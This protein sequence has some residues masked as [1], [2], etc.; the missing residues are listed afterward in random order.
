MAPEV[1]VTLAS[2][3]TVTG[4]VYDLYTR[5]PIPGV[6]VAAGHMKNAGLLGR[7]TPAYGALTDEQGFYR[8]TAVPVGSQYVLA[9]H[10][11]HTLGISEEINPQAG[12]EHSG[13]DLF[14]GQGGSV[15]GRIIDPFRK[16]KGVRIGFQSIDSNKIVKRIPMGWHDLTV[17]PDY[18]NTHT[19]DDGH[20]R[21]D[22]LP[23]GY[24]Y[25]RASITTGGWLSSW[26]VP[27]YE[28]IEIQEGKTTV[29]DINICKGGTIKGAFFYDKSKMADFGQSV[30]F[31]VYLRDK[32]APPIA[33]DESGMAIMEMTI[34]A[35]TSNRGV[36]EL[37]NPESF[38]F[39]GVCPGEYTLTAFIYEKQVKEGTDGRSRLLGAKTIYQKSIPLVVRDGETTEVRIDW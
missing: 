37:E 8:L 23:E 9:S 12:K 34:D 14:L 6:R 20:Y 7:A 26:K 30:E 17:F 2:G 10:P 31:N 27:V 28:A 36:S 4:T 3:A 19:D 13:V 15:E 1:E 24:S 39:K 33:E 35:A 38:S 11:G 5:K 21:I 29:F 16:Q 18:R 32:D 25:V 22:G